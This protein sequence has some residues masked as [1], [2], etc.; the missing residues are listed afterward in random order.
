MSDYK[1]AD[2]VDNTNKKK[3]GCFKDELNGQV[4]SEIVAP[5]PKC[6]AYKYADIE[7]KKAKGVSKAVV[8]KLI[9]SE[10]YKTVI[11]THESLV[12]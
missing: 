5:S 7:C 10:D 6:Y 11:D 3:L 9:N 4:M 2:M 8:D 1:R 12:R